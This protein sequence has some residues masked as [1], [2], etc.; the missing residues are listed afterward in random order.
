MT[1]GADNYS[2]FPPAFLFLGQGYLGGVVPTQLPVFLVRR[3]PVRACCSID[4]SI[5]RGVCTPSAFSGGRTLRGHSGD[6]TRRHCS[7]CCQAACCEPRGRASTSRISARR[8]RTPARVTSSTRSLPSCSGARRSSEGAAR[9]GAPCSGSR[10][11]SV[12]QNG[13]QLAALPSELTGVLTGAL[14]VS[15]SH[16]SPATGS[17]RAR[18]DGRAPTPS[19]GEFP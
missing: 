9:C 17:P 15:P 7:T 8:R 13:L 11:S 10:R 18:D 16:R 19:R 3:W 12:L 4:R 5:G 6:E 14:L 1:Q 2:G